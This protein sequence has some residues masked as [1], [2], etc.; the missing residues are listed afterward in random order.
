MEKKL[1]EIETKKK[2]LQGY[3]KA[4]KQMERSEIRIHEMRMNQL[5]PSMVTDG[6]PHASGCADLSKYA[7]L[8]DEEERKYIKARYL[9]MKR[10]QEIMDKI[11]RMENEDEKDV[12][13]YRYIKLWDWGKIASKIGVC[14]RRVH[15]IHSDALNHF[16]L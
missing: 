3:E 12:L 11:E 13:V 10:C 1:T 8:L 15:Y 14:L 6:M 16:C 2:Y 4:K 9:R 7:S 5:Y